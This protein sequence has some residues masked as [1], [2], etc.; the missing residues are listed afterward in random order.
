MFWSKRKEILTKPQLEKTLAGMND[1]R[2]Q[3][4]T[5]VE[6]MIVGQMN[7]HLQSACSAR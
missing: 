2:F 5:T 6:T 1:S 7:A 4:K 3:K